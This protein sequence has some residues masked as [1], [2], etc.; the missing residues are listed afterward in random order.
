[1]AFVITG[2]D[3]LNHYFWDSYRGDGGYRDQVLDFYRVVDGVV[4]GVLDRLQDDDVL[5]VVSDHGFE[6]EI[7]RSEPTPGT[8]TPT[9]STI[10]TA[11]PGGGP[12]SA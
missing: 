5:V 4:E 3:R 6:A 7:I 11:A 9:T 1:M 12:D 8:N 10:C 2:T